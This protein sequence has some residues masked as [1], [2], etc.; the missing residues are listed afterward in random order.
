MQLFYDLKNNSKQM[1]PLRLLTSV[2]SQQYVACLLAS[3]TAPFLDTRHSL[4]YHTLHGVIIKEKY[5]FFK[6][7]R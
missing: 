1:L 4:S 7:K 6:K 3:S 2:C 5:Y